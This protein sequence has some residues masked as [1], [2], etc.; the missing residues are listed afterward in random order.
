M[1]WDV[2]LVYFAAIVTRTNIICP[3]LPGLSPAPL[4]WLFLRGRT[5]LP[6]VGTGMPGIFA[7]TGSACPLTTG[8]QAAT[9]GPAA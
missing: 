4:S 1:R 8:L 7:I 2:S 5:Q 6:G 3:A 9:S